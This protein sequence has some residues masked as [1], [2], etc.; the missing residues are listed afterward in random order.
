MFTDNVLPVKALILAY[1]SQE[2]APAP[3]T[4]PR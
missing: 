1:G 4:D 2:T 3:A